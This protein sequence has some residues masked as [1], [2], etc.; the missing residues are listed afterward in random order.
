M[1]ETEEHSVPKSIRKSIERTVDLLIDN[2]D[3]FQANPFVISVD[4]IVENIIQSEEMQIMIANF[5]REKMEKS[6]RGEV[7]S[8]ES[9]D[10]VKYGIEYPGKDLE[11]LSQTDP[12]HSIIDQKTWNQE[13]KVLRDQL[14]SKNN[15]VFLNSYKKHI[16]LITHPQTLNEGISNVIHATKLY[17]ARASKQNV[18][19][20]F[21]IS[22]RIGSHKNILKV[23]S[24]LIQALKFTSR[25]YKQST[26]ETIIVQLLELINFG[27][28]RRK[29]ERINVLNY[30]SILDP[31]AEWF[32]D[33]SYNTFNRNIILNYLLKNPSLLEYFVGEISMNK[34][35]A[36]NLDLD[37]TVKNFVFDDKSEI[38]TIILRAATFS[39]SLHIVGEI[40]C[41]NYSHK[42]PAVKLK[43]SDAP[44]SEF[45][46]INIF[47]EVTLTFLEIPLQ[48]LKSCVII[49]I[50]KKILIR[51][52]YLFN[53]TE[54][55]LLRILEPFNIDKSKQL[56]HET[57]VNVMY[58]YEICRDISKQD[59]GLSVLFNFNLCF[60]SQE[61]TKMKYKRFNVIDGPQNVNVTLNKIIRQ[62]QMKDNDSQCLVDILC[63]FATTFLRHYM[64]NNKK[65]DMDESLPQNILNNIHQIL[66]SEDHIL[67]WYKC[68]KLLICVK[69]LYKF[70]FDQVLYDKILFYLEKILYSTC[71]VSNAMKVFDND[72]DI[73]FLF[74]SN[75]LESDNC[76]FWD[77][78][79]FYDFLLNMIENMYGCEAVFKRIK[80][81]VNPNL[82]E[83]WNLMENQTVFISG[84]DRLTYAAISKFLQM[85]LTFSFSLKCKYN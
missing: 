72:Q 73:L 10:E 6:K 26:V 18:S 65:Y 2:H 66:T 62:Y 75:Y 42:L 50:L 25:N 34:T 16:M 51:H 14:L 5:Q 55:R 56:A 13:A 7:I 35:L 1:E 76:K 84:S 70:L 67:N 9:E 29:V 24:L 39:H 11:L 44:G 23:V 61:K 22:L 36:R 21:R 52:P 33:L 32:K 47:L 37:H 54:P 38:L 46:L 69:N 60:T 40:L 19:N 4:S 64:N 57:A 43:S 17:F 82:Y 71:T 27:N 8:F 53:F 48:K 12:L 63:N 41:Y 74:G 49:E 3:A 79:H 78:V 28:G 80:L 31:T 20:N 45:T 83:I 59:N 68:G 77:E 85:I 58:I 81:I 30:F 15:D